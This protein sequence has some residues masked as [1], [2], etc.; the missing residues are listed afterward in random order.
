MYIQTHVPTYIHTCHI[1]TVHAV[2]LVKNFIPI[3]LSV[4]FSNIIMYNYVDTTCTCTCICSYMY[5]YIITS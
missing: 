4:L 1:H 3:N 2:S 5:M